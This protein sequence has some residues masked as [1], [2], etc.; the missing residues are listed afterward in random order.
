ML[1]VCFPKYI[2]GGTTSMRIM[3]A[4]WEKCCRVVCAVVSS[5]LCPINQTPFQFF[6][7]YDFTQL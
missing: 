3:V 5:G 1:N 6:F 4:S 7:L 2:P